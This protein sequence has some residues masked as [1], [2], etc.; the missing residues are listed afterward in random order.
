MHLC[1]LCGSQNKQQLFPYTVLTYPS[2]KP[3]QR[4]FT[5]RY[6]MGVFKSDRYSFVIKGLISHN[7]G[8]TVYVVNLYVIMQ[9]QYQHI[10][11]VTLKITVL[12]IA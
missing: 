8:Y 3:E 2:L 6:E 10:T 1:V 5:A 12:R 11:Y 7:T 4:V 9:L